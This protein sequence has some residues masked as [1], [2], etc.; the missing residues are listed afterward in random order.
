MA[1]LVAGDGVSGQQREQASYVLGAVGK[2][3]WVDDEALIDAVTAVSG[4]GPAYFYLLMEIL[5]DCAAGTRV[6][7]RPGPH[8]GRANRV[9]RPA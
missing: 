4:S 1:A 6:A 9:W 2:A 7:R 8:P 5:E 3:S